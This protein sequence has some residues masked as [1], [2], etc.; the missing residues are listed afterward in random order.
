MYSQVSSAT[1]ASA[2]STGSAA[3]APGMV[4]SVGVNATYSFNRVNDVA[5]QYLLELLVCVPDVDTLLPPSDVAFG[6]HF[7]RHYPNESLSP[8]MRLLWDACLVRLRYFAAFYE[9]GGI[10]G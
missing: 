1:S 6:S 7:Q 2:M 3:P 5:M 8:S 9:C 10:C 4:A